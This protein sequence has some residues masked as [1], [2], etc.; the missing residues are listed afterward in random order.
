MKS[1][2]EI[3]KKLRR[4]DF[5]I[6]WNTNH[7]YIG[8]YKSAFKGNGMRFK[9]LREYSPGDDIRFIDWKVSARLQRTHTKIFEEERDTIIYILLDNSS[10]TLFG[11]SE[12][13]R[14]LIIQ[15]SA[16][17]AYSA[18][19]N[20]DKIGLLVFNSSK[21]IHIPPGKGLDIQYIIKILESTQS[22]KGKTTISKALEFINNI[23]FQRSTI[24]L[25]SDFIDNNYEK[26]L[27][28]L[29]KKHN[30]IGIN[31]IDKMDMVLP[32]IGLLEV[33]D[34]ETGETL[35]VDSSNKSIQKHY[36]DR[37]NNQKAYTIKTFNKTGAFLLQFETGTDY[38][39][40][41]QDYFMYGIR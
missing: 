12:F 31:V 24:I 15:L 4:I 37:F 34:I 35:F 5:G 27:G 14:D 1:T 40:R 3:L 20:N 10:S 16:D 39:Q 6:K 8:T 19:K 21:K 22:S 38:H 23:S 32:K 30:V 41:L 17:L 2:I 7:L 11:T 25:I 13:K 9:E 26:E 29:A 28:V 33:S 36:E 18:I